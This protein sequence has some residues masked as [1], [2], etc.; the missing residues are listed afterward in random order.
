MRVCV[1]R[2]YTRAHFDVYVGDV[3]TCATTAALR[4]GG[5]ELPPH[6]FAGT[7]FYLSF[8]IIVGG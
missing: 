2:A 6:I 5:V 1:A 3:G 4:T 7:R 8:I